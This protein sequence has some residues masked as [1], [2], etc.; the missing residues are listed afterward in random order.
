M[1]RGRTAS[2]GKGK[3]KDD[4]EKETK[5]SKNY[6]SVHEIVADPLTQLSLLHWGRVR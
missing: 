2:K 4:K 6:L 1:K 3:A 5:S